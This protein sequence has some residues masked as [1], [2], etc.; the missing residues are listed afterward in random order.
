MQASGFNRQARGAG[1]P[2]RSRG[3][4]RGSR[5]RG[6]NNFYRGDRT[7]SGVVFGFNSLQKLREEDPDNI[8]LDLAS[9]RCLPAFKTLLAKTDMKDDMIELVLEVLAKACDCSSPEYFN[10]LLVELPNSFFVM[11]S[12]K[13]YITRLPLLRKP[14]AQ[15]F[16]EQS[17]KLFTEILQRIPSALASLPLG[18]LEQAVDLLVRMRQI[19]S[20]VNEKMEQLKII[21]QESLEKEIRKREIENQ[22]K[23]RSRNQGEFFNVHSQ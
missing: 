2:Y 13:G 6:R 7:V 11:I 3:Y 23:T 21:K 5:G 8:V 20:G 10:K 4:Q 14:N 9:E 1:S 18:D 17:C 15:M 16:I 12:L 19:G 22:R